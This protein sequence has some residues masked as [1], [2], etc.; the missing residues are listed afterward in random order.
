MCLPH[1]VAFS[2]FMMCVLVA[3]LTMCMLYVRLGSSV[4]INIFGCVLMDS[5][6]LSIC[7]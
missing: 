5:F 6:V 3:I 1:A 7:R 4:T 2:A